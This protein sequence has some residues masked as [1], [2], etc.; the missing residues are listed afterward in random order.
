M[1]TTYQVIEEVTQR[2]KE[3][4]KEFTTTCCLYATA[5]FVTGTKLKDAFSK[6]GIN[7]CEAV[8]TIQ[9]YS[10]PIQRSVSFQEDGLRLNWPGN[11]KVRSQDLQK[12][13]HD[14]GQFYLFNTKMYLKKIGVFNME[15]TAV[16]VSELESQ[17]IDSETDWKLA[18]LKYT[19]SRQ[20]K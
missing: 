19:L 2:Y 14:C 3:L 15:S 4:G 20:N 11:L 9:E 7:G 18:E 12:N 6:L 13:Y 1:A 10:Y 5:P 16:V 17:D 8:Y